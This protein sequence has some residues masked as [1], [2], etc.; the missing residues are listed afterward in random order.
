MT[1]A[2]RQYWNE[3]LETLPW[4]EVER[5]QAE[6]IAPAIARIRA[7]S[8][9]YREM[10]ADLPRELKVSQFADL[11]RLPFTMKDQ[12][13]AAQDAATDERPLVRVV[14]GIHGE[15]AHG[16]RATLENRRCRRPIR[17]ARFAAKMRHQARPRH[18]PVLV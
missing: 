4:A 7:G 3:Q 17:E 12:V 8:A 9:M 18:P 5:W 10:F 1:A 6:R 14:G 13:R 11:A 16:Q 2:S 15:M